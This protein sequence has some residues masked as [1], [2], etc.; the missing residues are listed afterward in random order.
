MIGPRAR[1]F[2]HV[3]ARFL[4]IP[5]HYTA[6]LRFAWRPNSG[7]HCLHL[8]CGPVYIPG[9][10]NIDINIFRKSDLWLDLRNGLP[11][12][13]GSV[14]FVYFCNSIHHLFPD[15]AIRLLKEIRRVLRPDGV[16]R[17][18]APSFEY[19]VKEVANGKAE[20][21]WPRSFDD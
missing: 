3:L 1:A 4:T 21:K 11:F 17:V 15:D 8:A 18:S 6:K 16:A 14:S 5:N 10:I 19:A 9:M 20:S 7:G 13:N 12:G 2:Y